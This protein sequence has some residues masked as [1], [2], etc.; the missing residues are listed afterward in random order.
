MPPSGTAARAR[1]SSLIEPSRRVSVVTFSSRK[2]FRP[3]CVPTQMF[4]SRSSSKHHTESAD[5]PS[6]CENFSILSPLRDASRGRTSPCPRV[7]IHVFPLLSRRTVWTFRVLLGVPVRL[8]VPSSGGWLTP[9]ELVS[10]MVW[11]ASS[12]NQN[13]PSAT[14]TRRSRKSPGSRRTT[15]LPVLNQ[16]ETS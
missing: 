7:P 15:L 13:L 2:R 1:T 5:S 6:D 10:Q 9:L 4:C 16:I 12:L 11:L 14:F 8:N 3:F